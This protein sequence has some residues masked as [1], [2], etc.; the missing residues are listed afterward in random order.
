MK[1]TG[2]DLF[3]FPSCFLCSCWAWRS[4]WRSSITS[5]EQGRSTTPNL[6]GGAPLPAGKRLWFQHSC[7]PSHF[8]TCVKH[9]ALLPG[10]YRFQLCSCTFPA[11]SSSHSF[12]QR[13]TQLDLKGHLLLASKRITLVL[14][15]IYFVFSHHFSWTNNLLEGKLDFETMKTELKPIQHLQGDENPWNRN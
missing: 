11:L 5:T 9:P 14:N 6:G 13:V 1:P 12:C 7:F 3:P 15:E 4:P 8:T 2:S 10:L